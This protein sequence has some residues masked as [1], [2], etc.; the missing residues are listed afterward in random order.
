MD[1]LLEKIKDIAKENYMDAFIVGSKAHYE[2]DEYIPD[3]Q[4]LKLCPKNVKTKVLLEIERGNILY[5]H[6]NNELTTKHKGR[7]VN[8]DWIIGFIK[9]NKSLAKDLIQEK[10]NKPLAP[11]TPPIKPEPR[12]DK[13]IIELKAERHNVQCACGGLAETCGNCFGRGHYVT[14]GL[15]K[16]V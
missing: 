1:K 10:N 7:Q 11:I 16:K 6:R 2:D 4:L 5:R 9:N 14:D 15:G 13:E 8:I 12:T 3:G